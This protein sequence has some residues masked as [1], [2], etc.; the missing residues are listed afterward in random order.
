MTSVGSFLNALQKRV[1]AKHL[2]RRISNI[3][4]FN[5]PSRSKTFSIVYYVNIGGR[6]WGK[7]SRRSKNKKNASIG[8]RISFYT[9]KTVSK[10]HVEFPQ[11]YSVT[12]NST[13]VPVRSAFIL[14]FNTTFIWSGNRW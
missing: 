2:N 11:L 7:D 3:H 9:K 5:E 4:L 6:N 10:S 14:K 1:Q 12:W 13:V 8:T